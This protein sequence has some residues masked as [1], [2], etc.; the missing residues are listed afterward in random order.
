MDA[1]K[2][3]AAGSGS[4][5]KFVSTLGPIAGPIAYGAMIVGMIAT[6]GSSV[7]LLILGFIIDRLQSELLKK[8]RIMILV[9]AFFFAISAILILLIKETNSKEK[10]KK[11]VSQFFPFRDKKFMLLFG[12]TTIWWFIMSFLWPISP[13]VINS[14]SPTT[15]QVAIYSAVFSAGIAL[16]QF[17]S[18][19]IADKIGRHFTTA[20]GFITLC[21]VPLILAFTYSW[22]IIVITNIFGGIG[23]GFFMVALNSELLHIS[24]SE[25]RGT[26]TGIYNLLTGVITF[27]GSFISGAIFDSLLKTFNYFYIIKIY[28]LILTA[29]RCLATIPLIV[30]STRENRYDRDSTHLH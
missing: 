26:Y 23:N 17:I 8:Y 6:I 5:G 15:W 27:T 4:I 19:K 29:A 2:N 16:G 20:L 22:Y 14:V 9:G 25:M 7:I 11:K 13:F 28:L 30:L 3:I 21:F 1:E 18:G 12:S 24:G 10:I